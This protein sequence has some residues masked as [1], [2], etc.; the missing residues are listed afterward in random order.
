MIS[1]DNYWNVDNRGIA[2]YIYEYTDTVYGWSN[3]TYEISLNEIIFNIHFTSKNNCLISAKRLT[4]TTDSEFIQITDQF[5]LNKTNK[6]VQCYSKWPIQVDGVSNEAYI[7]ANNTSVYITQSTIYGK[8]G[9]HAENSGFLIHG[10]EFSEDFTTM[11]FLDDSDDA[12]KYPIVFPLSSSS[13]IGSP[14]YL[15]NNDWYP[16]WWNGTTF[17]ERIFVN[18]SGS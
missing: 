1:T 7:I 10:F 11:R 5:E 2:T 8:V 15:Q 9:T 6:F 13:Y 14:H 16:L 4:G 18:I 17:N 3:K 12:P